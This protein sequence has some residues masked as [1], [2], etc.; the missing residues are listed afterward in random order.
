MR[1]RMFRLTLAVGLFLAVGGVFAAAPRYFLGRLPA[2]IST[3]VM[4][5]SD[6]GLATVS[7]NGIPFAAVVFILGVMLLFLSAVVYELL[8]DKRL[9]A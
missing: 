2:P 4:L 1:E 8:P 3:T 5:S 7:S 6:P 9:Q